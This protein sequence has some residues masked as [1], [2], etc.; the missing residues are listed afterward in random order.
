MIDICQSHKTLQYH[1]AAISNGGGGGGGLHLSVKV[2][3]FQ[4]T[5][6]GHYNKVLVRLK[7]GNIYM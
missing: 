5:N 7:R 1:T 6:W 4:Q 2:F 3:S